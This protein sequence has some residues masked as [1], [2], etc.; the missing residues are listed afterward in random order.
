MLL[1]VGSNPTLLTVAG[2]PEIRHLKDFP[3]R[4]FRIVRAKVIDD[5]TGA[6]RD[7]GLQEGI[8]VARLTRREVVRSLGSQRQDL[9]SQIVRL[10]QYD[11]DDVCAE[12]ASVQLQQVGAFWPCISAEEIAALADSGHARDVAIRP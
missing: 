7:L 11:P 10:L 12:V 9:G 1:S 2:K 6:S 3:E 4:G 5:A 8:T